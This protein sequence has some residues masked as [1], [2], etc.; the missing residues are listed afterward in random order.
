MRPTP[1]GKCENSDLEAPDEELR[2][3]HHQRP[4]ARR[5][6]SLPSRTL[7]LPKLYITGYFGRLLGTDVSDGYILGLFCF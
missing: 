5:R 3:T 4:F 6:I 1:V 2:N 7:S